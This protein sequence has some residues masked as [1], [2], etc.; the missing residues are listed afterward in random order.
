MPVERVFLPFPGKCLFPSEDILLVWMSKT[1]SLPSKHI[2]QG[3]FRLFLFSIGMHNQES[4]L[5]V[6]VDCLLG[7]ATEPDF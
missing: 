1:V 5:Q 7:Y 4:Y 3:M 6:K 2:N